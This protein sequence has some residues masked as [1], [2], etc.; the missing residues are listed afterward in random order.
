MKTASTRE[1][2][3]KL[4]TYEKENGIGSVYSIGLVCGINK[5]IQ[6]EFK[7]ANG[8][9]DDLSLKTEDYKESVLEISSID[10]SELFGTNE[11]ILNGDKIKSMTNE[12]LA[13][14]SVTSV[15]LGGGANIWTMY[16]GAFSGIDYDS[17]EEAERGE[18]EWL[19]SPAEELEM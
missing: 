17:R 7:V 6:Y 13:K 14:L 19:Q 3:D 18:L 1:I 16:R 8:I 5:T 15:V 9:S 12:E 4:Q 11:L 2:V 10:E